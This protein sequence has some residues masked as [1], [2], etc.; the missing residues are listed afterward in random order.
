MKACPRAGW[1]LAGA[2]VLCAGLGGCVRGA[3]SFPLFGSFF[4]AWMFCA[5]F[6]VLTAIGARVAFVVLGKGDVYPFQLFVCTAIGVC[7]AFAGWL[8]W[9]G[10]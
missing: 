6:G 8:I 5:L 4:P 1:R 10:R 7:F 2:P 3:P 9:F